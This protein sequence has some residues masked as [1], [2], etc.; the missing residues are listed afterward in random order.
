MC[1]LLVL[2]TRV[3]CCWSDGREWRDRTGQGR[4]GQ[5]RSGEANCYEVAL[6]LVELPWS[7]GLGEDR[8]GRVRLGALFSP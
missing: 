1:C 2:L 3:A 6:S 5:I 8:P 7:E 4:I